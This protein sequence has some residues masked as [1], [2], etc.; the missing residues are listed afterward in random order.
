MAIVIHNT[1][2]RRA[3]P[4]VPLHA[5]EVGMY[6]CGPTVYDDCHIGHLMGPVLFDAVARWLAARG[7][8]V[9]LVNNITDIDAVGN[10]F[11]LY[12]ANPDE[13]YD[14]AKRNLEIAPPGAK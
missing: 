2:S 14:I 10:I 11:A 6:V 13:V 8:R 1:L 5:G 7:Y 3:E 12:Y 9:R 4:L